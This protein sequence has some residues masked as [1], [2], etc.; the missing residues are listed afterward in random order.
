MKEQE[1]KQY[2]ELKQLDND[3]LSVLYTCFGGYEKNQCYDVKN[4][5]I[6]KICK[7]RTKK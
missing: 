2:I 5:A 7:E 1:K 3:I 4:D 6:C